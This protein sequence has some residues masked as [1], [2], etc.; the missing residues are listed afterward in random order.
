[1]K[2]PIT[3]GS[4]FNGSIHEGMET[5]ITCGSQNTNTGNENSMLV[6]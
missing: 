6:W 4:S 3:F 1:M 2:G 5:P